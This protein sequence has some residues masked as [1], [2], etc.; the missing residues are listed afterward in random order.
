MNILK[1]FLLACLF[2]LSAASFAQQLHTPKEVEQYMKKSAIEYKMDSLSVV[3]DSISLPLVDKGYFFVENELGG[4]IQKKDFPWNKKAQRFRK[5]AIKF[6]AK[7]KYTKAIKFYKKAVDA[8]PNHP[9]LL[10]ELANVFWEIGEMDNAAFW[11]KKGVE[12]NPIDFEAHARLA[13]S[14][15][16]LGKIELAKNHI[17]LAHLYNRNHPKVIRILENIFAENNLVYQD[18]VFFPKYQVDIKSV[19][20]VSVQANDAPWKSFAACKALWQTETIYKEEMSRLANT[21]IA[22]IEQKECLLNALIAYEK[23]EVGKENF[24]LLDMLE[25]SLRFGLVDDFILYE[26]ELRK[27]PMMIYLLS[28]EKFD[29]LLRYLNTVRVNREVTPE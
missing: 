28:E 18:A 19:T 27:D 26:I 17:S 6:T 2:F 10:N 13:L 22:S 23:M 4:Q 21:N 3:V 24:P 8:Q 14:Y 9:V 11:A 5:K 12:L 29:R 15:Q 1:T 7:N 20:E 16:Q 25:K